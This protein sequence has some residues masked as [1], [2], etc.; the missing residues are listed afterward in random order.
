MEIFLALSNSDIRAEVMLKI[1]SH[2]FPCKTSLKHHFNWLVLVIKLF[3]DKPSS[4]RYQLILVRPL[5]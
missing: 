2:I 4:T 3:S 1:Y 5:R